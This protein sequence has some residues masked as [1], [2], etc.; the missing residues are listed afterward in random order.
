MRKGK[1]L[2]VAAPSPEEV[3][4]QTMARGGLLHELQ[5][6]TVPSIPAAEGAGQIVDPLSRV[7]KEGWLLKRASN[8]VWQKRYFILTPASLCYYS[9]KPKH[10]SSPPR[11]K[12][13]W[14]GDGGG[15]RNSEDSSRRERESKGGGGGGE[16][17]SKSVMPVVELR[18]VHPTGMGG[19]FSL[20]HVD[21]LVRL[22]AESA[23]E[24]GRWVEALVTQ[25]LESGRHQDMELDASGVLE[26]LVSPQLLLFAR[27]PTGELLERCSL[28]DC[29][30]EMAEQIREGPEVKATLKRIC[31]ET[32][33]IAA[34][35]PELP[36]PR[37]LREWGLPNCKLLSLLRW[38]HP[39]V[40]KPLS[41]TLI[42]NLASKMTLDLDKARR[43]GEV[44]CL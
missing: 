1:E 20:L 4:S 44:L 13:L 35:E 8:G 28:G 2:R 21:R 42:E 33:D 41:T 7:S 16:G 23:V 12:P 30:Q 26:G 3:R 38:M 27:L 25:Q 31:E 32:S 29:L 5:T 40:L 14:S 24:A 10:A 43:R 18:D 22:R 34:G 37:A 39:S 36:L 17:S 6:K 19:E 9:A 15:K 11:V